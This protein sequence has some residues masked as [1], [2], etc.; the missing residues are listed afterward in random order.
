MRQKLTRYGAESA[1]EGSR[2]TFD[3][4]LTVVRLVL[5]RG[6]QYFLPFWYAKEPMFWLPH[7]WFPY[8]AEW[9][10]SFP[11]GP[12][13]SVSITSWQLACTGVLQLLTEALVAA[14]NLAMGSKQKTPIPI[15]AETKKT[16][17]EGKAA[18]AEGKK[19]L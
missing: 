5:T 19:E 17:T 13:G 14:F 16:G 1:L 2:K 15:P 18:E 3:N 12:L 9:I 4:S 11:R 7:G 10:L 6:M 8:Y